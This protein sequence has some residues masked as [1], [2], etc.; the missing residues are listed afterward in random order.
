MSN[1]VVYIGNAVC[2]ENGKAKGGDAGD[3]TGREVRREAW[4]NS[5]KGW[6]VFRPKSPDDAEK[7]ADA[8]QGAINNPF[9]G[10]DQGERTTLYKAAAAVGFDPAA[11]SV[12]CECDC[13]S[14]VRV[15]CAFA[16]IMLKNFNTASEP[17]RL[18][19][20]GKFIELTGEE[21]TDR[22][23]RLRRGD[24]LVTKTRGHTCVVLNNGKD[25]EDTGQNDEPLPIPKEHQ[26]VLVKGR[27]IN[28]KPQKSVYIRAGNGKYREKAHGIE[29]E[30]IGTAHSED[31]FPLI[32]Q[33]DK[34]P[35]WYRI[36]Y[37]HTKNKK[38]ITETG[39][40]SSSTKYTE[41]VHHV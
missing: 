10:Y 11:V 22:P 15:C 14:L 37:T 18:K 39:F 21:Y 6:R 34:D 40:I 5:E 2:D 28:G 24:V 1:N 9:I 25:A 27:I 41:V 7:I 36:L 29:N 17:D 35:F 3:Q 8:M 13:S 38:E 23:D 20:S 16:G 19:K 33:A 26:Y 31:R 32:E 12:P 30:V 4:H